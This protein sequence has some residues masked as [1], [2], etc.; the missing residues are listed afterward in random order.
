MTLK[1]AFLILITLIPLGIHSQNECNIT[2]V[3]NEGFLIEA[4]GKK[5]LIDALF[6]TMSEDWCDSPSK[7]TTASMRQAEHPFDKVDIIAI[8]HMHRDHFNAAIVAKHLEHNPKGVVI[9]PQQVGTILSQH[10]IAG[11]FRDRIIAI[12]PQ[13]LRDTTITVAEIPIR[14]MRLEH[15]HYMIKD[16]QSGTMINKH[17]TV[18]NVGYVFNINGTKIFHCGDTNVL[19]E[20]EYATFS[21]NKEEI[22]IAFLERAFYAHEKTALIDKHIDP[23]NIILM[24]INPNNMPMYLEHFKEAKNINIFTQKMESITINN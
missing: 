2:Y 10:P 13:F 15:S 8:T 5:V 20:E 21:L 22:D 24:H 3:S 1:K 23:K 6:D 7:N 18:E 9:C 4:N 16:S 14:I 17:H 19:N 12:T 11:K